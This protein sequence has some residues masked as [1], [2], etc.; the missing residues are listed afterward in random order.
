MQHIYT[1]LISRYQKVQGP[2]T[3][4]PCFNK[5]FPAYDRLNVTLTKMDKCTK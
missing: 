3:N 2:Y 4:R 5:F 1:N